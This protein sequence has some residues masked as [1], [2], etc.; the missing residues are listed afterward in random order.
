MLIIRLLDKK[1]DY[2]DYE[3]VRNLIMSRSEI[4]EL[5]KYQQLSCFL[6]Y[7][8]LEY[9]HELN[10]YVTEVY[11][12]L[13]SI[14]KECEFSKQNLII[15]NLLSSGYTAI[16]ISRFINISSQ[17]TIFHRL[18]RMIIKINKVAKRREI[19]LSI[20]HD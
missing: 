18:K 4:V 15:L 10:Q 13:D 9:N 20:T 12:V 3:I 11:S 8:M 17:S 7:E 2:T 6:G 1:I 14:I 19:G 16:E 5:S